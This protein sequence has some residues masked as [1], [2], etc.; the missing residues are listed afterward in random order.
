[1]N[2]TVTLWLGLALSIPVALAVNLITPVFQHFIA[3]VN[4]GQRL[5]LQKT[6]VK[7]RVFAEKLSTNQTAAITYLIS[8]NNLATRHL[9]SSI[10]FF[11]VA[12]CLI[13]AARFY[14]PFHNHLWLRVNAD[15]CGSLC[16][17]V[18]CG[19]IVAASNAARTATYVQNYILSKAEY[20][21]ENRVTP[22]D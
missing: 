2:N 14:P 9:V 21:T 11:I 13:V 6:R 18:S 5:K 15:I 3:K 20:R 1:M 16:L 12:A 22:A 8:K 19:D 17:F 10:Y 4:A 7:Q